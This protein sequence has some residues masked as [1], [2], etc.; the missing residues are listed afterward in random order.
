VG[1]FSVLQDA[2]SFVGF[3][4]SFAIVHNSKPIFS[5]GE[6]KNLIEVKK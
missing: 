5:T 1:F 4:H 2:V 3:R 6:S